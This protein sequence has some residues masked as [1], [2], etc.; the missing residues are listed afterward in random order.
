MAPIS[1]SSIGRYSKLVLIILYWWNGVDVELKAVLAL[2]SLVTLFEK[3]ISAD[4][5]SD[6]GFGYQNGT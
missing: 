6:Q 3:H 1:R 5:G 4:H 2:A